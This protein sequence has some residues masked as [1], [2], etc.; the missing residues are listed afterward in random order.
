[1][2]QY[3]SPQSERGAS[4]RLVSCP[5]DTPQPLPLPRR[6]RRPW[7]IL[8]GLL[9]AWRLV[10][11]LRFRPSASALPLQLGLGG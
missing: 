11:L 2:T 10:V 1:M 9:L 7:G 8:G 4:G 3:H 5:V 6:D